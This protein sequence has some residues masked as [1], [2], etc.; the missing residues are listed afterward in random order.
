MGQL[1]Y[2]CDANGWSGRIAVQRSGAT[3]SA[4]P[5]SVISSMSVDEGHHA[6]GRGS[7]V[8]VA[9]NKGARGPELRRTG[10][11][12]PTK[13]RSHARSRPCSFSPVGAALSRCSG[14]R[15]STGNR[16]AYRHLFSLKLPWLTY[17]S[18]S[19]TERAWAASRSG[20]QGSSRPRCALLGG[21][22][23]S[24]GLAGRWKTMGSSA[25]SW[26]I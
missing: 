5:P 2:G 17:G 26:L 8:L 4:H 11:W 16:T 7:G 6:D 21:P 19:S 24:L 14:P 12:P 25:R 15:R 20:S 23:P 10:G 1:S 9:A 3:N 22:G 18:S 13:W